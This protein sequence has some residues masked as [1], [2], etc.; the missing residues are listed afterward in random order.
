MFLRGVKYEREDV[1]KALQTI[2]LRS[3]LCRNHCRR[4]ITEGWWIKVKDIHVKWISFI[5]NLIFKTMSVE[6][7][8][9]LETKRGSYSMMKVPVENLGLFE[10]VRSYSSIFKN[11]EPSN[12]Y[13][14]N[15]SIYTRT[16]LT[17]KSKSSNH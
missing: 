7:R 12:P 8:G 17:R 1:L 4:E 3:L 9:N 5:L 11:Q 13:D 14:L 2:N 10:Q 6:Y 15:I 16:P